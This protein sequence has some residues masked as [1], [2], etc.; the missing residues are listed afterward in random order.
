MKIFGPKYFTKFF[1][2]HDIHNMYIM[3]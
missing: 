3:I 2:D 1:S